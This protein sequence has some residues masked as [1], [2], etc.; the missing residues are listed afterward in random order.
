MTTPMTTKCAREGTGRGEEKLT[1]RREGA[2]GRPYGGFRGLPFGI[3]L[4]PSNWR[5]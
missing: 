5:T 4:A 2:K 3:A 1:R